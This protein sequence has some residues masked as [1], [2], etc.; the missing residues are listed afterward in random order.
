MEHRQRE[1][2]LVAVNSEEDRRTGEMKK[3]AF[4]GLAVLAG[5]ILAGCGQKPTEE[6]LELNFWAMWNEGEPQ[7]EVFAQIVTE[8]QE[9]HPNITVKVTWA[10]RDVLTKVRTAMA[11]GEIPDILDQNADE[12]WSPFI[13]AGLALPMDDVLQEKGYGE[14]TKL[15][16]ILVDGVLEPY[17]Y[18]GK[19]YFIPYEIITSAFWYDQRVFDDAGVTP[20]KTWSDFLNVCDA[21]NEH[22]IA[23]IGGDNDP[24]Y[25]GYYSYW[26]FQRVM[27]PG[28]YYKL[29]GDRT[30]ALW[31]DPGVLEVAE[32]TRELWD[33]GCFQEGY[34]GNVWP[35]G[36]V[37]WSMGESAMELCGSWLPNEVHE[38]AAEGYQ[39]RGFAFPEIEGAKGKATELESFLIGWIVLKEAK[40][41]EAA[42]EFIKFALQEQYQNQI[43]TKGQNMSA[44]KGLQ[45]PDVLPDIKTMFETATALH[46]PY[47]GVLA[48]FGEYWTT[49]FNPLYDQ[50]FFGKITPEEFVA[51]G[52]Q[53]SID[54]W[55]RYEEGGG[56][57]VR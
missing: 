3:K 9:A 33:R 41:P 22:G 49:V 27:G 20:P 53:Q 31:D 54:Y 8:F 38:S 15:A 45:V 4:F 40:H 34:E 13:K 23:P 28:F 25:N 42:I 57:P 46:K 51:T 43:V 36:Q 37:G 52:K 55:K 1:G 19:T 39:F 47:D 18:E 48:D 35:A 10:G 14:D 12:L 32:R 30:G 26:L 5:L 17:K 7:Q 24:W 2:H 44:R 6:P 21:L 16:D 11:G 50:L 29:A 56:E